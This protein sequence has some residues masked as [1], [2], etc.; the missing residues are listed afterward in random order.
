MVSPTQTSDFRR[1]L[2]LVVSVSLHVALLVECL[3]FGVGCYKPLAI[4][5][6]GGSRSLLVIVDHTGWLIAYSRRTLL[7]REFG[8][9]F[10]TSSSENVVE[11]AASWRESLAVDHSYGHSWGFDADNVADYY[12]GDI[13]HWLVISVLISLQAIHHR[14]LIARLIR[15]RSERHSHG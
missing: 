1:L 14:R 6:Q 11:R 5:T 12:G 13:D 10:E 7:D 3:A 9:E 8:F 2:R 15:R 4:T